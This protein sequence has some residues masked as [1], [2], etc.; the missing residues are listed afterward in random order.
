M[1]LTNCIQRHQLGLVLRNDHRALTRALSICQATWRRCARL[2]VRAWALV[3]Q[4]GSS[5]MLLTRF[6]ARW[7][8]KP[9]M[10]WP[11]VRSRGFDERSCHG[12]R[13]RCRSSWASSCAS[14]ENSPAG[15]WPGSSVMRPPLDIPRAISDEYLT[16]I[17]WASAKARRRSRYSCGSPCTVPICGSSRP[18]V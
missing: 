9:Q 4:S 16:E 1:C 3:P 15:D 10:R 11:L 12:D 17:L 13:P 8:D 2:S 14:V 6:R 18:S 5:R 7:R